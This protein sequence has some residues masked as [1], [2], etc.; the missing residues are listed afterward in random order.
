[1]MKLIENVDYT[2]EGDRIVFTRDFLLRRG[3]CCNA[4]C[5]N[6]PY[7]GEARAVASITTV[8]SGSILD[9]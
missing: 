6:C 8:N 4:R 1:M 2:Y 3:Y 9:R 7:R 5:R